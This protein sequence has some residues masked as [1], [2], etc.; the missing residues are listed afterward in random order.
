M[1]FQC[2]LA[3]RHAGRRPV[4]TG[5]SRA[6]APTPA[7]TAQNATSTRTTA[8]TAT[9]SCHTMPTGALYSRSL[10]STCGMLAEANH[11][12]IS[13]PGRELN[14]ISPATTTPPLLAFSWTVRDSPISQSTVTSCWERLKTYVAFRMARVLG[15]L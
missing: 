9:T 5:S 15:P 7:T 14:I 6:T 4:E 2:Y 8:T 1:Y 11:V 3:P 12:T 10:R 13:P